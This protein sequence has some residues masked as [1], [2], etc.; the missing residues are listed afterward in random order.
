VARKN[1]TGSPWDRLSKESARA[2]SAFCLYRDFGSKRSIDA[3]FPQPPAASRR[4]RAPRTWFDWS[5][6][7]RWVERAQ[8]WDAHL[9]RL[10]VK[11]KEQAARRE[12][13]RW[14]ERSRAHRERQ[15]KLA[16]QMM[17]K[18]ETILKMPVVRT[19][20]ETNGGTTV[21]EPV[22]IR[23]A[24]AARL[25]SVA[26][27]LAKEAIE[28]ARRESEASG[29]DR[30]KICGAVFRPPWTRRP[31]GDSAPDKKRTRQEKAGASREEPQ[32]G[33]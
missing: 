13:E 4:Q 25:S 6:R 29:V 24:D 18:A 27:D 11:E 15:F 20:V 8:A 10:S 7:F 32:P 2:Y 26:N 33:S 30:P 19:R 14:A 21:I 5:R 16:D 17:D 12:A 22:K 23:A 3:A 28:D 1:V 31:P 9:V